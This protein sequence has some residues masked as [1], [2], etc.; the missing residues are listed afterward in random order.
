MDQY[1]G[2]GA[3]LGIETGD[4]GHLSAIT[5]GQ[6]RY[7]INERCGDSYELVSRSAIR[8]HALS[9]L[10]GGIG[11][12]RELTYIHQGAFSKR[13]IRILPGEHQIEITYENVSL[14]L[15]VSLDR[16]VFTIAGQQPQLELT[17]SFG[18]SRLLVSV[19][20]ANEDLLVT[21][22]GHERAGLQYTA[23]DG[24]RVVLTVA[25][26][27]AFEKVFVISGSTEMAALISSGFSVP[28]RYL[29]LLFIDE[30]RVSPRLQA[31]ID[32]CFA[33]TSC[34]YF[35]FGGVHP[36]AV[37]D[38]LWSKSKKF[39]SRCKFFADDEELSRDPLFRDLDAFGCPRARLPEGL[40]MARRLGRRLIIDEGAEL[41]RAAQGRYEH[42]ISYEGVGPA[43]IVAANFAF[44]YEAELVGVGA[45][46][47]QTRQR[48]DSEVKRLQT[49]VMSE[50]PEEEVEAAAAGFAQHVREAV[51]LDHSGMRSLT[52]FTAGLPYSAGYD[53]P[54]G[55]VLEH[56]AD[57]TVL[58]EMIQQSTERPPSQIG[59]L[60]NTPDFPDTEIQQTLPQLASDFLCVGLSAEAAT[61]WN[62]LVNMQLL[63]FDLMMIVA[64]GGHEVFY[65]DTYHV[66]TPGGEQLTEIDNSNRAVPDVASLR[67]E[68]PF[69]LI[70]PL[71]RRET[72]RSP[73]ISGIMMSDALITE[74]DVEGFMTAPRL[75][76]LVVNNG[77]ATWTS[78]ASA[79]LRQGARG[80]VGTLWPVGDVDAARLGAALL[81]R[82]TQA[83]VAHVLHASLKGTAPTLRSNYVYAGSPFFQIHIERA[84][85][86][87]SRGMFLN[88]VFLESQFQN[89]VRQ[90]N[91]RLVGYYLQWIGHIRSLI[92]PLLLK[93]DP[94]CA[95]FVHKL[96]ADLAAI[97]ESRVGA[98]GE[99]RTHYDRAI[100]AV[101]D[102][103]GAS[104]TA[105]ARMPQEDR[106]FLEGFKTEMQLAI[107]EAHLASGQLRQAQEAFQSVQASTGDQMPA[108]LRQKTLLMA[109]TL[110]E[111]VGDMKQ[112]RELLSEAVASGLLPREASDDWDEYLRQLDPAASASS[113]LRW[114]AKELEEFREHTTSRLSVG[115]QLFSQAEQHRDVGETDTA[116][117]LYERCVG[118][119]EEEGELRLVAKTYNNMG[120]ISRISGETARAREYFQRALAIKERFGG[121]DH[122]NT[123]MH[124]GDLE[125]DA[126]EKAREH[127]DKA[128]EIFERERFG[129]GVAEVCLS[130]ARLLEK[131]G[132][133]PAAA[134]FLERS[135]E[136][137]D[138][139]NQGLTSGQARVRLGIVK[140]RQGRSAEAL[141]DILQGHD[142]LQKIGVHV[143]E[144]IDAEVVSKFIV[145]LLHD[146][147]GEVCTGDEA[148]EPH[149]DF[150]P[151][152]AE[153]APSR[154]G[155]E[156]SNHDDDEA[157]AYY[158][159]VQELIGGA[160][161]ADLLRY[162]FDLLVSRNAFAS[163]RRV[164]QVDLSAIDSER[165][166]RLYEATGQHADAVAIL[167]RDV[168]GPESGGDLLRR[169]E[170]L[171]KTGNLSK[172]AG[173]F[174]TS[175]ALLRQSYETY[176]AL[177]D[178]GEAYGTLVELGNALIETQEWEAAEQCFNEACK[179]YVERPDQ[180]MMTG[181][182]YNNM[183]Y[184]F[185]RKGD[186][187]K[188]IELYLRC[189]EIFKDD[190]DPALTLA[191]INIAELSLSSGDN[192]R[193]KWGF[194]RVREVTSGKDLHEMSPDELKWRAG[195]SANLAMI[196]ASEARLEDALPLYAEALE[197]FIRREEKSSVQLI[198]QS[199]LSQVSA[200]ERVAATVRGCIILAI[201][202]AS[203]GNLALCLAYIFCAA[204][205][206]K[207]DFEQLFNILVNLRKG[208]QA[209]EALGICEAV[210]KK[211]PQHFR[212]HMNRGL[213]LS[214]MKEW[215]RADEDFD[216]CIGQRPDDAIPW[217]NKA[218][219]ASARGDFLKVRQYA[220]RAL[221]LNP[222][223][224]DALEFK[225]FACLSLQ[226]FE[227]AEAALQRYIDLAPSSPKA[228]YIRELLSSL[229]RYNFDDQ[230]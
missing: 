115:M 51:P 35:I 180:K 77:C 198:L 116:L 24:L 197:G 28:K 193:A 166:V 181:R 220:E 45:I 206:I 68:E 128:L 57:L 67:L 142:I 174:S 10:P 161:S 194:N 96:T 203:R 133:L 89:V 118:I 92:H 86:D 84:G 30:P 71:S 62:T 202:Q 80:Y 113:K 165:L 125:A 163:A 20:L 131:T 228:S 178:Q 38:L 171:R 95:P 18:R 209:A 219:N 148:E 75:W 190:Y 104:P 12:G 32:Q 9:V 27:S 177:E 124:L 119:F 126:P 149:E 199:L 183:G 170:A 73:E 214:E 82:T 1:L 122:G 107:C 7:P 204:A 164:L 101:D 145:R 134:R 42:L 49:V 69:E 37:E 98:T 158:R 146:G 187:G 216:W 17:D 21:Y 120:I 55:H 205:F 53:I 72:G 156:F 137:G 87:Q 153:D 25:P 136:L 90:V 217:N 143:Q 8:E 176:L 132:D 155:R 188:A 141:D 215:A 46:S 159:R 225:A 44:H 111:K 154:G 213:C 3:G 102:L 93:E 157:G 138:E 16:M 39:R 6:T 100:S 139:L 19:T 144:F 64:H 223:Y 97:A 179:Y 66:I 191:L 33:H 14:P 140:A 123:L 195:A 23:V 200:H 109:V 208:G 94:W 229:R 121:I 211:F 184:L 152:P 70:G 147:G 130:L 15:E 13:T 34:E 36:D 103:L 59:L 227:Q 52:A 160:A 117:R 189:L 135:R 173:E 40:L 186:L 207:E 58:K 167:L 74:Q 47:S 185:Q 43:A 224:P 56:R 129:K 169:A 151:P 83:P 106:E 108:G 60:V 168:G 127:Y 63:P 61:K 26:V 212:A 4:D 78:L 22:P 31:I 150:E 230:A 222:D 114:G 2:Y 79:F 99:F 41:P 110:A 226:E 196:L 5:L 162:I 48:I 65:R 11:L 88:L 105:Q 81:T 201:E 175:V 76:G 218:A 221:E 85:L 54:T 182:L 29:P 210:L 172:L 50:A 112:L 192:E 91:P